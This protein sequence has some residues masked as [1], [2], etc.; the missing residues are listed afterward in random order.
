MGAGDFTTLKDVYARA[1][2]AER[3]EE[4]R[5][6]AEKM[7]APAKEDVQHFD[8]GNNFSQD[9]SRNYD[10]RGSKGNF[11]KGGPSQQASRSAQSSFTP[12]SQAEGQFQFQKSG[13][14]RRYFCKKCDKNHPGRDCK[15]NKVACN[16]CGKEG[17]R[18]YECFSNPDATVGRNNELLK[19]P[20][21][22]MA[23]NRPVTSAPSTTIP[24]RSAGTAN[25]T[26]VQR[27]PEKKNLGNLNHLKQA[28]VDNNQGN[29]LTDSGFIEDRI[30][31]LT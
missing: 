30:D 21:T 5:K 13:V 1:S 25:A 24:R 26:Y 27:G 14:L 11:G 23:S 16:Y 12:R 3:I 10:N 8:K 29:A 6:V 19:R 4:R 20:P 17:H 31:C 15:G 9:R 18:A 7:K 2:N 28:D 22:S